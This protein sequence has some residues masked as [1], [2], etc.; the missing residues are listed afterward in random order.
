MI[1]LLSNSEIDKTKW[2]ICVGN[3]CFDYIFFQ[4]WYLD[5]AF[6]GWMALVENDYNFIFPVTKGSKLGLPYLKQPFFIPYFSIHG[7]QV[8]GVDRIET[9]FKIL[10][11]RFKVI[12][13]YVN[14]LP[15]EEIRDYKLE[16]RKFQFIDLKVG[17]SEICARY[18]V[19]LKRILK[20][21]NGF[22]LHVD[23]I[24][25]A[26]KAVS[27]IKEHVGIK[28]KAFKKKDY[29]VLKRLIETAMEKG[30]SEIRVVKNDNE[31][32]C[33]GIFFTYGDRVVY[34]KGASSI[35]GRKY[36]AMHFLFDRYICELAGTGKV[37]DFGGSMIPSV[38]EFNA[39]FGSENCIYSRLTMNKLPFGLRKNN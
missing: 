3:S 15:S 30:F 1:R 35:N 13:L 18:S 32:L 23:K 33:M 39:K 26:D 10:Q 9:F 27:F 29:A 31:I 7:S 24:N 22:N 11:Q 5:I 19:N 17:Y 16:T 4:S 2:D 25:D 38:A 8:P 37:F 28:L 36:S 6:P 21:A 20:K 34:V 12:D 14:G